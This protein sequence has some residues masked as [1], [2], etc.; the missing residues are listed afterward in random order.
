[1]HA[2]VQRAGLG[3]K[4]ELCSRWTLRPF[5]VVNTCTDTSSSKHWRNRNR[6][7]VTVLLWLLM[8]RKAGSCPGKKGQ[9]KEHTLFQ[10]WYGRRHFCS[11]PATLALT[12][13]PM[14]CWSWHQLH[15]APPSLPWEAASSTDVS[16]C[17]KDD[18]PDCLVLIL[19]LAACAKYIQHNGQLSRLSSVHNFPSS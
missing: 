17:P 8:E 7:K 11:L 18:W 9:E 3:G 5:I 6:F 16:H 15:W 13:Y 1:M 10:A 4:E 12:F 14:L 19:F 2:K